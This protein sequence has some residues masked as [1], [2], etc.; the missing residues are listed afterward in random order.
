MQ[1]QTF[2]QQIATGVVLLIAVG[3]G[4]LRTVLG[5]SARERKSSVTEVP[6]PSPAPEEAS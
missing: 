1:V 3:F 4:R 2:Y 6:S 5:A